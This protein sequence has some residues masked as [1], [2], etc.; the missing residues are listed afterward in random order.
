MLECYCAPVPNAH[1]DGP[2]EGKT[3]YLDADAR[4]PDTILAQAA[5][6]LDFS[7]PVAIMLLSVLQVI[8]D[9]YALTSRLLRA[10]PPGSYLAISIPASARGSR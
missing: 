3:A 10:V 4:D 1:G 9:P 7:R 5:G 2:P 6:T 8:E